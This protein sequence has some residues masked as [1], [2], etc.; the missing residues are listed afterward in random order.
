LK[1]LKSFP[2]V[3]SIDPG[4]ICD[5]S[6]GS[7]VINL[8]FKAFSISFPIRTL[9]V[10]SPLSQ[11]Y[12]FMQWCGT[13]KSPTIVIP[14]KAGIQDCVEKPLDSPGL[15]RAGAGLQARNDG[16]KHC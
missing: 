6:S 10:L 12:L 5:L 15:N 13:D 3:R 7:I 1:I 11:F 2:S 16:V 14:A 4:P 8:F 9:M